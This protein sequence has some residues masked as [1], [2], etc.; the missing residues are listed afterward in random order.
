MKSKLIK[1][2]RIVGIVAAALIIC[3]LCM[4]AYVLHSKIADAREE[5]Q[6]AEYLVDAYTIEFAKVSKAN[7]QLQDTN[8]ELQ[9]TVDTLT[10]ALD[11]YDYDFNIAAPQPPR[12]IDVPVDEELQSYIWSLCCLYD[13]DDYYEIIYAIMRKESNF[14]SNAISATNDYGLMQI[15]ISNHASLST[16]LGITDFLDPYQNV[17]AG[18]Y[19]FANALHKYESMSDALMAYN[20]GGGGASKLWSQGI[21]S[22]S[23]SETVLDYYNQFS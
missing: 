12:Y 21:H 13:I 2:I 7:T 20:M 11:V 22:T 19:M 23:Y 1:P 5:T 6:E 10:D 14:D 15:N 4:H 17:H 8:T 9:A 3:I 18:I 16:K